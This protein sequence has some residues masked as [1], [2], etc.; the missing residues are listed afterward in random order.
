MIQ[1]GRGLSVEELK[2]ITRP[3]YTSKMSGAGMGL[4][5]VKYIIEAHGGKIEVF[6]REGEGSAFRVH[7]PLADM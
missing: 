6:S 4:V 5:I 1:Y 3:F 7:L 2:R